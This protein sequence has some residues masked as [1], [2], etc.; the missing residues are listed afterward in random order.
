MFSHLDS[1]ALQVRDP[2]HH[3]LLAEAAELDESIKQLQEAHAK[4]VHHYELLCSRHVA[5]TEDIDR[6]AITLQIDQNE[7][8]A[9]RAQLVDLWTNQ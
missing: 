1:Y 9:L 8:V 6:K 4:A 3:R 2:V 7:C 5:L